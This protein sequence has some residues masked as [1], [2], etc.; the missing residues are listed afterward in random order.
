[1]GGKKRRCWHKIRER[2]VK[3]RKRQLGKKRNTWQLQPFTPLCQ[4]EALHI[5]NICPPN[6]S[7]CVLSACRLSLF[8]P[9]NYPQSDRYT[10]SQ[11]HTQTYTPSPRKQQKNTTTQVGCQVCTLC[12]YQHTCTVG[13]THIKPTRAHSEGQ[14]R[15]KKNPISC[16]PTDWEKPRS[17]THTHTHDCSPVSLTVLTCWSLHLMVKWNV[18]DSLHPKSSSSVY[19]QTSEEEVSDRVAL[20]L[21]CLWESVLHCINY[22]SRKKGNR[23]NFSSSL[24]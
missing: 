11:T 9:R 24:F 18:D 8:T 12:T 17:G 2:A 4:H 20:Q 19:K 1:M 23:S 16:P 5:G 3:G 6:S 14:V 21:S 10:Q 15:C 13:C 7:L 22:P